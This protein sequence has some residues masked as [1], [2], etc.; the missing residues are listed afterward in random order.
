M[1]RGDKMQKIAYYNS[2][3]G[4]ILLASDEQSFVAL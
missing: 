4:Q 1:E 3:V 2:P